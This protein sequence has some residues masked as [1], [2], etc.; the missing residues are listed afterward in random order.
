MAVLLLSGGSCTSLT[1]A[2][3]PVTIYKDTFRQAGDIIGRQPDEVDQSSQAYQATGNHAACGKALVA[4]GVV[5]LR[6]D[7]GAALA[8]AILPGFNLPPQ[9]VLS[10]E[11]QMLSITGLKPDHRGLGLGFWSSLS[12]VHCSKGF[13]GLVLGP[14]GALKLIVKGGDIAAASH[15]YPGTFDAASSHFLSYKVDTRS[16]ALSNIVLDGKVVVFPEA[17]SEFFK[18]ES[19][20]YVGFYADSGT[21]KTMGK[22]SSFLV[23]AGTGSPAATTS[24]SPSS[25]VSSQ[26]LQA[27]SS[28]QNTGT[29]DVYQ[30]SATVSGV[31]DT[32]TKGPPRA[33]LWVPPEC[34]KVRAVIIGQHNMEEES[35][36]GNPAF[37]SAMAGL[38]F[39]EIWITPPLGSPHFRFDRGMGDSLER[40]MRDLAEKSGYKELEFAPLVPIGHSATASFGWDMAAWNPKRILAVLSISGSWPYMKDGPNSSSMGASPDWGSRNIDGVP[41]LTI[42]GEY[43]VQGNLLGGWYGGLRGDY[44]VAHPKTAFTQVVEPGHGHFDVSEEKISLIALFLKKAAQYR[45]STDSPP[46]AEVTLGKIDPTRDGWLYDAWRLNRT[47]TSPAAPVSG[48]RGNKAQAFWAFDEEMAKT[49]ETFQEKHR[50]EQPLLLAYRQKNGL[51]KPTPDHAMVHL[52]FEP[53]GDGMTFRLTGAFWDVVPGDGNKNPMINSGK[54]GV[55]EW[56]GWLVESRK[57]VTVKAG[58]PIP[59]PTVGGNLMSISRICGPVVRKSPDTFALQFYRMGLDNPRRSNDIWLA[60]TWPGDGHYKAMVQQAELRFPLANTQGPPQ[61]ITFPAIQNQR[62]SPSIPPIQLKATSSA[63]L[64]VHYYIRE[65]PALVDDNGMLTFTPI[66]TRSKY[67]IQ[68]TVVAWQWGRSIEPKV[69]SA[70]PVEQSFL[71]TTP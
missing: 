67:P 19:L 58:D 23:F 17:P 55:G 5:T 10:A 20:K 29:A 25:G 11:L 53:I 15:P 22:V 50:N 16:G 62:S 49:I 1:A 12:H 45:L 65:G 24:A 34:R 32:E 40:L 7:E 64:P 31:A 52:K 44:L 36:L 66:P 8:F 27:I 38:G 4:D 46:D 61:S 6:R 18:G 28:G 48:Y 39:A 14:D 21:Q 59:H 43:E 69:Q 9:I 68:V 47:P 71:I 37:R 3:T 33:F 70:K 57:D 63:N 2:A 60:L 51:T 41:G 56:G 30:W 26:G 54:E 42:K 13:T 35:I